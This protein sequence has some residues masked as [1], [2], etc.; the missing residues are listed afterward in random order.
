MCHGESHLSRKF[1]S[2][3]DFN[4]LFK[5]FILVSFGAG[6]FWGVISL[7]PY[8]WNSENFMKGFLIAIITPFLSALGSAISSLVGF[9]FYSWYC[10]KIEGQQISGKFLEVESSKGDIQ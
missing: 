10:N 5:V 8:F 2:Q 3:L 9:P 1:R 4:L 6:I 7:I